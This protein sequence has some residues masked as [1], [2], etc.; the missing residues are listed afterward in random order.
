MSTFR[1][2]HVFSHLD[3]RSSTSLT[4]SCDNETCGGQW[5]NL[6]DSTAT[7]KQDF[8][9]RPSSSYRKTMPTPCC[10]SVAVLGATPLMFKGCA[11]RR[12]LSTSNW[13]AQA[14]AKHLTGLCG[15]SALPSSCSAHERGHWSA[16]DNILPPRTMLSTLSP[17]ATPDGWF[18]DGPER[19]ASLLELQIG[20]S[21]VSFLQ[22][23]RHRPLVWHSELVCAVLRAGEDEQTTPSHCQHVAFHSS[24]PVFDLESAGR[25]AGFHLALPG[26]CRGLGRA[27]PFF[28]DLS[29]ARPTFR[30]LSELSR[31]PGPWL[32]L[33]TR[34]IHRNQRS[35]V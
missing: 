6:R 17:S 15:N 29:K 26:C 2:K 28:S 34:D 16:G 22:T 3:S 10:C 30:C 35:R 5:T 31:R 7:E 18:H 4:S 20:P 19:F 24:I 11:L 13:K 32:Y 27:S 8:T 23:S 21:K 1:F 33:Q 9:F 14:E 12:P 25:S